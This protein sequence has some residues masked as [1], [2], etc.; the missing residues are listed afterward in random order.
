MTFDDDDISFWLFESCTMKGRNKKVVCNEVLEYIKNLIELPCSDLIEIEWTFYSNICDFI[1]KGF[2]CC[3]DHIWMGCLILYLLPKHPKH[4]GCSC[5]LGG[6]IWPDS[7]TANIWRHWSPKNQ[8]TIAK[9]RFPPLFNNT[10]KI[11]AQ[12]AANCQWRR[13]SSISKVKARDSEFNVNR[14]WLYLSF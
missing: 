6:L 2:K 13:I 7:S 1:L 8:M 3:L 12:I 4:G 10:N 14:D 5:C 11:P 9:T